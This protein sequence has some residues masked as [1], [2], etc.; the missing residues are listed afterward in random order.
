MA[1]YH[2]D[3]PN[4]EYLSLLKDEY[5][6]NPAQYN[7][8]YWSYS[9]G[10]TQWDNKFIDE[11]KNYWEYP[12]ETTYDFG[13]ILVYWK[14]YGNGQ[15]LCQVKRKSDSQVLITV[16]HTNGMDRPI[17]EYYLD[18]AVDNDNEKGYCVLASLQYI[19]NDGDRYQAFIYLA[20]G[21]EA[22]Y[23]LLVD[24]SISGGAGSGYI[25]NSLVSNKKMVGYNVPTS[26]SE[27]TKT[28]SINEASASPVS[29]KPKIGNGHARIKLLGE[30]IYKTIEQLAKNVDFNSHCKNSSISLA[31]LSMPDAL[32]DLSQYYGTDW[33]LRAHGNT[34]SWMTYSNNVFKN[35]NDVLQ[36]RTCLII[37][38]KNTYH[39]K[40][41]TMKAKIGTKT[42]GYDGIEFWLGYSDGSTITF[43][44]PSSYFMVAKKPVSNGADTNHKLFEIP[45]DSTDFNAVTWEYDS[46]IKNVNYIYIY[47]ADTYIEMKDLALFLIEA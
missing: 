23:N 13:K 21:G 26:S 28:E 32:S 17:I 27:S 43:Y 40:K 41:V 39:V 9:A 29:G 30:P 7:F 18:F 15:L 45:G 25:G 11:N 34:N 5:Y 46:L 24:T 47:L 12:T 37:P 19:P 35:A 44:D 10:R 3:V 4:G 33:N 6:T 38:L 31:G 42:T 1:I 16:E 2:V 22:L 36:P 20:D 14:V 8:E